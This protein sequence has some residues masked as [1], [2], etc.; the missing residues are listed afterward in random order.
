MITLFNL[1]YTFFHQSNIA[2]DTLLLHEDYRDHYNTSFALSPL[3]TVNHENNVMFISIH[4][5]FYLI[6]YA[7]LKRWKREHEI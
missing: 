3:I 2:F 5:I 4:F 6:V 7:I 1:F